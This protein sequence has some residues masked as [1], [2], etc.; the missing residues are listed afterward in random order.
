MKKIAVLE[1]WKSE[2]VEEQES[3]SLVL[4]K[5]H[6][7]QVCVPACVCIANVLAIREITLIV[8]EETVAR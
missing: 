6:G 3:Y 2:Q 5:V 1:Y 8:G 7:T 4:K